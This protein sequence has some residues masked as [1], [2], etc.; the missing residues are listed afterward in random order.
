V[1]EFKLGVR[2]NSNVPA[3]SSAAWCEFIDELAVNNDK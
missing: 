1:V 2:G 3:R